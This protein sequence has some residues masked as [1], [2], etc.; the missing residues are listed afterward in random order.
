VD[1]TVAGELL[2]ALLADVSRLERARSGDGG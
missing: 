1:A 2:P